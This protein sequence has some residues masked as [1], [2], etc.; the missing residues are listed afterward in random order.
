MAIE[1]WFLDIQ[2]VHHHKDT[3]IRGATACRIARWSGH[4]RGLGQRF[5]QIRVVRAERFVKPPRLGDKSVRMWHRGS[6]DILVRFYG[7]RTSR[8]KINEPQRRRD[9]ELKDVLP[10]SYISRKG[11]KTRRAEYRG[12][13]R[14]GGSLKHC[15]NAIGRLNLPMRNRHAQSW[16][17]DS[18]LS[19]ACPPSRAV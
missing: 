11:A 4:F 5:F 8:R 7:I 18:P 16:T 1:C 2:A 9:T 19:A 14:T 10:L 12:P 15:A 3:E 13:S 6:A 17:A